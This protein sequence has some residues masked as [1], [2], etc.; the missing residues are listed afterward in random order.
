MA[1]HVQEE[2]TPG[3]GWGREGGG[4]SPLVYFLLAPSSLRKTDAKT[5]GQIKRLGTKLYTQTKTTIENRSRAAHAGNTRHSKIETRS[6]AISHR[7]TSHATLN[8]NRPV[9]RNTGLDAWEA[10]QHPVSELS[11]SVVSAMRGHAPTLLLVDILKV[12]EAVLVMVLGSRS[13][14][15]APVLSAV[16]HSESVKLRLR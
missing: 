13:S 8:D 16:N 7:N 6:H 9:H 5:P 1:S 2:Y 14:S 15:C 11:N 4:G 3:F 12:M 10:G